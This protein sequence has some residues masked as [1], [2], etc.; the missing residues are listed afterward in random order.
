MK[1]GK[2][3]AKGSGF[4][5]RVCSD[6]SLWVTRGKNKDVFWRSAMSG[7]RATIH[8]KKGETNRQAGDITAVAVEGHQLTDKFFFELKFYKDLALP[9]FFLRGNG[10]LASFWFKTC[11]Q[12]DIHGRKPL[13][14]AKQN[15]FPAVV[16]ARPNE[17][18]NFLGRRLP[19]T[20]HVYKPSILCSVFH[21]DDI[22]KCPFPHKVKRVKL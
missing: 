3:K 7:G 12:A 4:E 20:L 18:T 1:K 10:L 22:L 2:G 8:V 19:R 15:K 5:R 16:L 21:L 11:D 17:L 9:A 6:L 14:I 13:L